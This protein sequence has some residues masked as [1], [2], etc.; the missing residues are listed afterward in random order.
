[1][2]VVTT[3]KVKDQLQSEM[4]QKFPSVN[5]KWNESLKEAE[6]QLNEADI[7]ITYGE[8]LEPAHIKQATQL[9]WIMVIS[10]GVEEMPLET[11][12]QHGIQLT[13]A[14][15]IH[16]IP[17]A[18]YVISML[19]QVNRQAK[20]LIKQ[21]EEQVWNP[22]VK[23]EEISGKTMLIAGT[24]AIGQ[25]V[26]RL[27]KAFGMKTIGISNS[28]SDREHFDACYDNESLMEYL[29]KADFVIGVLPATKNTQD[30]FGKEEFAEM[31]QSAIFL[32]MGRGSTVDE[33]ALVDALKNDE[34]NHAVLDV[35]KQEPLKNS[36]PLW[37][38]ENTTIT[39]HL[40]GISKHYQPR[41]FK[42]FEE[43]LTAFIQKEPLN[44]NVV[45]PKRGY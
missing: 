8:D 28:G 17:M 19:L 31:K 40:S 25:E 18:E 30:F 29:P 10:A 21:E 12:D 7:I 24:G 9:K 11:I 2:Q 37:G 5:F 34:I 44:R 41:A 6:A 20:T 27:A 14:S 23:M 42:I 1:M 33:E 16:A 43:N 39:P 22:K 45:D 15:G 13:N 35:A 4:E 38:L 26:A 36:S 3:C 32:N